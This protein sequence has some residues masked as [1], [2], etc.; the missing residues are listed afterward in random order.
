M[1]RPS[2]VKGTVLS[3]YFGLGSD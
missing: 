1:P 2:K 3:R